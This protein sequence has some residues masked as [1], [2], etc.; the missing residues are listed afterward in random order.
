MSSDHE[1]SSSDR[2]AAGWVATAHTM[3]AGDTNSLSGLDLSKSRILPALV[4][5]RER[6][7]A[8]V[9]SAHWRDRRNLLI[10][11]PWSDTFPAHQLRDSWNRH[12]R[13]S[14]KGQDVQQRNCNF[15][16]HDPS[17]DLNSFDERYPA[18]RSSD[19]QKHGKPKKPLILAFTRSSRWE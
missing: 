13:T 7:G 9:R 11:C 18:S 10:K 6:Q 1:R 8:P 4:G 19:W 5:D 14:C 15:L 16:L 2:S 17:L 3:V 12:R